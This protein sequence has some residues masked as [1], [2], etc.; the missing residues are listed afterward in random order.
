MTVPNGLQLTG[1]QNAFHK[2]L[3]DK[4]PKLAQMYFGALHTLEQQGNPER[5][6]QVAHSIRELMEKMPEYLDL[7]VEQNIPS[8]K[9]RARE[10]ADVWNAN[11]LK[12]D[13][14][15]GGQWAG[16]IDS[17]LQKTLK[18]ADEFVKG[19]EEDYPKR[20]AEV[21]KLLQ[22]I[23]PM[24]ATLPPPIQDIRISEW[25]KCRDFFQG[26]AHHRIA[27]TEDQMRNWLNALERFLLDRLCPR[28]FEDQVVIEDIIEETEK[29][30]QA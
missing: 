26:V 12:S 3:A 4:D 28:T 24:N 18:K 20:R 30:A 13:C 1:Q 14:C 19:F 7:P 11:A 22:G 2:A 8:L 27:P 15:D 16:V 23:D 21:G 29:H 25:E 10:L 6:A 9:Q 17:P 5:Y